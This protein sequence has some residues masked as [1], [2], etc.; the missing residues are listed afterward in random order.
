M[1]L[2]ALKVFC[3]IAVLRSFSK[4]AKANGLTQPAVS[5]HIADLEP[6]ERPG[7]RPGAA[8]IA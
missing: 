7:L 3:D 5:R 6:A 2:E 4:A 8:G 1:Q